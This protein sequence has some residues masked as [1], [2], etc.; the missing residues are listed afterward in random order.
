MKQIWTKDFTLLTLSNFLLHITYYALV[1]AL[2]IYLAYEM[3]SNNSTVGIV[4]SVYTIG[5]VVIRPF[6][7]FALDKFGYKHVF[8]IA[9]ILYCILFIGYLLA[10]SVFFMIVLRFLQGL[11]WGAATVSASTIGVVLIPENKR[12]E[13]IGYYTIS[14]TLGMSVGPIIGLFVCH[15]LGYTA[16][17]WSLIIVCLIACICACLVKFPKKLVKSDDINFSWKNLIDK[18]SVPISI[19]LLISM[20]TYGGLISFV[21]LYGKEIGIYNSSLFFLVLSIAIIITRFVCGKSF[22]KNGPSLILT[23]SFILMII[24]FLCL[25]F[26]KN[27]FGFYLAA[28]IIGFGHG[29]VF[30][31]F[32]AMVSTKV[33]PERRGVANSTLYTFLDMG[34]SFGTLIA[35]FVSENSSISFAF[36]INAVICLAALLIFRT[37]T[38]KKYYN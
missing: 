8:M 18:E 38:I 33:T 24:G 13:G 27:E 29:V 1:S 32:Y 12:G 5:C 35:G 7:G 31:M 2:P 4:V 19:N 20:L 28:L 15:I 6:S 30:P 34:I 36:F 10:A 3:N 23:K 9:L 37:I 26:I 21:A 16:L 14:T 22:D 25:A 11:T 17:F